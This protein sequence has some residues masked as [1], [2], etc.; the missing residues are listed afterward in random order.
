M[1]VDLRLY[2]YVTAAT[3]IRPAFNLLLVGVNNGK[4]LHIY[5]GLYNKKTLL[6]RRVRGSN[7]FH[8]GF[9][10]LYF[11]KGWIPLDL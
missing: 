6:F 7:D 1:V 8:H 4:A 3:F 11:S 5:A 10:A 9:Y 2:L